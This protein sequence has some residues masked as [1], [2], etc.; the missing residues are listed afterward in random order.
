VSIASPKITMNSEAL[1]SLP[2]LQ[3]V[4]GKKILIF[5]GVG[6]REHLAVVLRERGAKVDYAECYKRKLPDSPPGSFAQCLVD[7]QISMISAN[8]QESVE[9][10][11]ALGD[12]F[13]LKQLPLVVPGERVASSAKAK[14]FKKVIMAEN[15]TDLAVV[16]ALLKWKE[17]I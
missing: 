3:E 11:C 8:S 15:A 9:N 12:S 14:G 10:L 7:N 2:R 4:T 6:G 13:T 17:N 1:L 5:R 16:S